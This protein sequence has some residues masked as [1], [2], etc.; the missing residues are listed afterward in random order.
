[1][2]NS[3]TTKRRSPVLSQGRTSSPRLIANTTFLP[4]LLVC[5]KNCSFSVTALPSLR[6]ATCRRPKTQVNKF[7][8]PVTTCCSSLCNLTMLRGC[9]LVR[10]CSLGV[11]ALRKFLD[12]QR[13]LVGPWAQFS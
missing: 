3:R 8:V 12:R 10:Y 13:T 9:W 1:M 7:I 6:R 11:S 2:R 5:L 4:L